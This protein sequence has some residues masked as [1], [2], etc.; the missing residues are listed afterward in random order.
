MARKVKG[1]GPSKAKGMTFTAPKESGEVLVELVEYGAARRESAEGTWAVRMPVEGARRLVTLDETEPYWKKP[2][3]YVFLNMEGAI[4]RLKPPADADPG[5]VE[6]IREHLAAKGAAKIVY[7]APPKKEAVP[8]P[9]RL[10]FVG[11]SPRQVV[12]KLLEEANT[13][14]RD[15]LRGIVEKVMAENGL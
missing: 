15:A 5:Q 1:P 2:G 10:E 8:T 4:V 3:T 7:V 14:D 11:L 12:E 6:A 9:A 13:A